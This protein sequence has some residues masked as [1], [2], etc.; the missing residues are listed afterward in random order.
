MASGQL[1]PDPIML[2]IDGR[3]GSSEPDCQQGLPVRRLPAHAWARPRRSTSFW[4]SAACRST[5]CSSC[6][7]TRTKW[8][9]VWPAR[10]GKTTSPRSSAERLQA[11]G[12]QTAPLLDY[13]QRRRVS[14]IRSTVPARPTRCS[15]A[16]RPLSTL[17]AQ[18]HLASGSTPP[19]WLSPRSD[20]HSL[21]HLRVTVAC[22]S[23]VPL[24]KSP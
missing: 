8:S 24:V 17:G 19:T 12:E 20:C 23:F 4:P 5:R 14:C 11:I 1:V 18:A 21:P 2:Q 3:R 6:G 15:I 9:A 10:S 16:S 7:S 13:Y 22:I